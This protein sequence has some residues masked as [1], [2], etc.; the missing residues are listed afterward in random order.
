MFWLLPCGRAPCGGVI[1]YLDY[2]E[3]KGSGFP[4]LR[5]GNLDAIAFLRR[6][7][8]EAY[9]EHPDIQTMAEESTDCPVSRPNYVGGLS[10]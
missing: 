6:F 4:T 2:S 9:R 1:L 10:A 5:E 8:E 7:N 3:K